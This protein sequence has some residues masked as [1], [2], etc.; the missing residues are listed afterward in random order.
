MAISST[1][2]QR[3]LQAC[4]QLQPTCLYL[5]MYEEHLCS[6]C[7]LLLLLAPHFLLLQVHVHCCCQQH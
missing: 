5:L 6:V 4:L 2:L 3:S 7:W 1:D